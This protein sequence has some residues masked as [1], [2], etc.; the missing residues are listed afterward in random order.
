MAEGFRG[1]LGIVQITR[2]R[3]RQ[4]ITRSISETCP[5]CGGTG[6]VET[7]DNIITRIERW[8]KRYK[9]KSSKLSAAK[10]VLHVNPQV[11]KSLKEGTISSLTRIS[12]KYL[13]RL[14]LVEDN[15]LA[16]QDFRFYNSKNNEDITQK[17]S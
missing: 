11:Y 10:L 2:Q 4:S 7:S 8:I 1:C 9:S 3:I 5:V 13:L 16:L 12:F 17:F 6:I 15:T 14:K